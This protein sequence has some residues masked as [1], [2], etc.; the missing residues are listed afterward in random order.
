MAIYSF[1]LFNTLNRP[2]VNKNKTGTLLIIEYKSPF[3]F[4]L[5]LWVLRWQQ[6]EIQSLQNTIFHHWL[7]VPINPRSVML[8]NQFWCW[9][10]WQIVNFIVKLW[11]LGILRMLWKKGEIT[12]YCAQTNSVDFTN[13]LNTN[14]YGWQKM[15]WFT[16]SSFPAS[17]ILRPMKITQSL[18]IKL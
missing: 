1:F 15:S 17:S 18:K 2:V 14:L 16:W 4:F 11:P 7:W 5:L 10:I 12:H 13:Y 3:S 9:K 8:L 6:I